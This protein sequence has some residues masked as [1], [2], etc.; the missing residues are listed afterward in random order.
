MSTFLAK[1]AYCGWCGSPD[2]P[3]LCKCKKVC[4][5]NKACQKAAWPEHRLSCPKACTK[6][7]FS[8][9]DIVKIQGLTSENGRNMNGLLAEVVSV[10]EDSGRVV[11]LA[12][13]ETYAIRRL[14]IKP[15]NMQ[16]HLSVSE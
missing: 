2:A 9:G 5:C 1:K 12:S 14:A 15:E 4:F 11:V 7:G 13:P 8:N 3:N 16:M 6:S 10:E